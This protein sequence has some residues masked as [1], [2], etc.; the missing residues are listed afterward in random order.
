MPPMFSMHCFLS[1]VGEGST[2]K[3]QGLIMHEIGRFIPVLSIGFLNDRDK[4]GL[5][6]SRSLLCRSIFGA[7]FW[8]IWDSNIQMKRRGLEVGTNTRDVFREEYHYVQLIDNGRCDSYQ[9]LV[10]LDI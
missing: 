8:K 10:L 3:V 4:D 2:R 7:M 9:I 6:F 5:V 1:G